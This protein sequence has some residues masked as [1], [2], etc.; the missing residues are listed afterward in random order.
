MTSAD[1]ANNVFLAW[2]ETM[3]GLLQDDNYEP[4]QFELLS[5][6]LVLQSSHSLSAYE[7]TVLKRILRPLLTVTLK[8]KCMDL[9]KQAICIL[10]DID[11]PLSFDTQAVFEATTTFGFTFVQS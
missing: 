5:M 11:A 10:N 8:W 3:E 6:Q 9:W 7:Q 1:N 2:V 4:S